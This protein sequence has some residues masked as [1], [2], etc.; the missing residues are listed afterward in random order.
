MSDRLSPSCMDGQDNND[1]RNWQIGNTSKNASTPFVRAKP[2]KTVSGHPTVRRYIKNDIRLPVPRIPIF[3]GGD[4]FSAQDY[5]SK[6]ESSGVDG[7]MVARG[8]LIK[9][10][11]FT[12]IKERREWDISSK[13]RLEFI[14]KVALPYSYIAF[15]GLTRATSVCRVWTRVRR[16]AL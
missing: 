11:I 12:E 9:P 15:L 6:V 10:W 1:T 5:W 8:A 7:V 16:R 2:M 13:E 4:A 3:G 14:R